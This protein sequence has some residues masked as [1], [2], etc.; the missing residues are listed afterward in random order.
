MRHPVHPILVHFPIAFWS[1][2]T[3]GDLLSLKYGERLSEIT[4]ACLILGTLMALVAMGGGLFDLLKIRSETPAM[5]VLNQHII[6]V[7]ITWSLYASSLFLR[8]E[9]KTLIQVGTLE[10]GLSVAG[11][12]CLCISGYLGGNLVYKYGVGVEQTH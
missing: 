9:E 11:F 7:V 2:A 4:G 10:V 1:F 3:L 12:L 5:K 6:I 8:I